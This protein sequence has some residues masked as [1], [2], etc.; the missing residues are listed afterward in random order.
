LRIL[1]STSAKKIQVGLSGGAPSIQLNDTTSGSPSVVLAV[2][3]G[4]YGYLT[5]TDS[6]GTSGVECIGQASIYSTG[7]WR[8][9]ITT[10]R[11]EAVRDLTVSGSLTAGGGTGTSGQVLVSTGTGVQWSTGASGTLTSI[12]SMTGPS[13]TIA[14]GSGISI[15]NASNTVTISSSGVVLT[16]TNQ[17]VEGYKYFGVSGSDRVVMYRPSDN[18][19]GIQT[20]LD[21]QTDPTTYS[22]GG[23]Q[24]QL[25]LQ[26]RAGVVGIGAINNAYTLNVSGTLAVT[27]TATISS[28]ILTTSASSADIG[29]AT[30]YFQTVYAENGNFAPAG[31][32][33]N[34]FKVRKFEVCDISGGG[35]F[36]DQ[37]VIASFASSSWT[38]RD[39]SGSRAFQ[40]N[41]VVSSSPANYVLVF[42]DL[43]PAKR[44]TGSGDNVTDLTYPSLGSTTDRWI[45]IWSTEADFSGTVKL[46]TSSVAGYVWTATDTVGNGGW[47]ASGGGVTSITGT[48]NQVIVS[49]ASTGAVTLNLPQDIATSSNVTFGSVISATVGPTTLTGLNLRTDNTTRWSISSVG[50]LIPAA[51]DTYDIGNTT[52]NRV[53]TVYAQNVDTKSPGYP[54]GFVRA[55]YYKICDI[56]GLSGEWEMSAVAS[57]VASNLSI[58]DNSGNLLLKA[59]RNPGNYI[60]FY[61]NLQPSAT[62]NYENGASSFRWSKVWSVAG[63]FSGAVGISGNLS[64]SADILFSGNMLPLFAG[65]GSIGNATYPYGQLHVYDAY[66]YNEIF[67]SGSSGSS[68]QLLASTGTGSAV[69]WQNISSRLSAGT[70]ISISGTTTATIANTGVTSI[71]GTANQVIASASTG[72]ITL[73]LPQSIATTSTVTFDTLT[74]SNGGAKGL[75]IKDLGGTGRVVLTIASDNNLYLDNNDGGYD[76]Y[77]RPAAG[78]YTFVDG[79]YFAP[80]TNNAISLGYNGQGWSNVYS[81]AYNA[82]NGSSWV[83]GTTATITGGVTNITV[84]D[85]IVTSV[86]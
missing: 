49:P 42:G 72:S 50:M 24:N 9:N 45:K 3:T 75:S 69:Q 61:A 74:L 77:I 67:A 29:D 43:F 63:D 13:I 59:F 2:S 66:I 4:L 19:I 7:A 85:G 82:Y 8:G 68:G 14:A 26:P 48:A 12:N 58:K 15:S 52:P 28:H 44:S 41:R 81:H 27:N 18:L 73:S 79:S 23:T 47:A 36:W 76:I 54:S 60:D 10:G 39:N 65:N 22:Y 84:V 53:R 70:G 6:T 38:L 55:G 35:T 80:Y 25:V 46:G 40:F 71:T 33:S 11:L 30:N 57:S 37:Q 56:T 83:S 51:F 16:T 31:V 32:V 62:N 34:Y 86:S 64:L 21:G 78:R 20:M 17:E 5:L 1:D